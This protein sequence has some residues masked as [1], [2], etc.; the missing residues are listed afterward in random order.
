MAYELHKDPL[1]MLSD[2]LDKYR[3]KV[4]ILK[5]DVHCRRGTL[6]KDSIVYIETNNSRNSRF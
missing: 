3:R 6:L 1:D 4:A 2:I 5:C